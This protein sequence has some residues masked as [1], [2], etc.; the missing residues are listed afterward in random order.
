M[1]KAPRS[2][3]ADPHRKRNYERERRQAKPWRNWYASRRW[4]RRAADQLEREPLCR[5]HKA[6]GKAVAATV[7]DH[8]VPH[9]GDPDLFWDGELQ[10]LCGHCHSSAKQRQERAEGRRRASLGR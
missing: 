3:G 6:K 7:A 10:S 5:M 8:V 1:P 2:L 9:R 4:K